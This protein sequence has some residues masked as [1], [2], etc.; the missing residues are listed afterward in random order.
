MTSVEPTSEMTPR[1]RVLNAVNHRPVDRTPC[2]FWAEEPTWRRLLDYAIGDSRMSRR[3]LHLVISL[4]GAFLLGDCDRGLADQIDPIRTE[5]EV[6]ETG[7]AAVA[8]Y[9]GKHLASLGYL[10]VTLPPYEADPTGK[11]DSTASIQQ[12]INDARDAQ[13]VCLLPPGRNWS[14]TQYRA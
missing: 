5:S 11:I 10:D 8:R 2:D 4:L 9:A 3:K 14:P 6:W 13:L 1:Q 7:R 12:A